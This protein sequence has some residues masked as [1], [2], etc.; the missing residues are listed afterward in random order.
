MGRKK[1]SSLQYHVVRSFLL[2]AMQLMSGSQIQP[3]KHIPMQLHRLSNILLNP[4]QH[5]RA[6][7]PRVIVPHW[8]VGEMA[9]TDPQDGVP[10]VWVAGVH[11]WTRAT[12]IAIAGS[13]LSLFAAALSASKE[14]GK[15]MHP[16]PRRTFARQAPVGE[17][18]AAPKT[19]KKRFL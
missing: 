14:R 8:T 12:K 1:R 11:L 9:E 2:P 18:N 4:S 3:S 15:L 7:L 10:T 13:Q 16:S 19:H 17:R 6:C 5:R